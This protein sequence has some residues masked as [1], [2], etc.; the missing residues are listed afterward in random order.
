MEDWQRVTICI[1][2]MFYKIAPP[3]LSGA[4]SYFISVLNLIINFNINF[5]YT[6]LS[7]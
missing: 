1:N 6:D 2:L 4:N 3:I 7:R 5:I